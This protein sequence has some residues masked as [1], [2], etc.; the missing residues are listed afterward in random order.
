MKRIANNLSLV[1][2]LPILVLIAGCGTS[3]TL[4]LRDGRN[5]EGK[6]IG[7]TS[8]TISVEGQT[9][10]IVVSRSEVADIDHP[11]NVAATIGGVLTAYGIANIA[12]GYEQCE[13][14]GNGAYCTGVFLP[15]LLGLSLTT[16][17]SVVWV[18]STRNAE[19][20]GAPQTAA[21]A[22]VVPMVS[23]DKKEQVY[24][25]SALVSF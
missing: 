16:Y 23:V 20:N 3:A 2:S 19:G 9:E 7:S 10:P 8:S 25:A 11:G 13:R 24:G 15:A 5:I 21:R 22:T 12:T 17:G 1:L 14:S 6:I 18:E 4:N